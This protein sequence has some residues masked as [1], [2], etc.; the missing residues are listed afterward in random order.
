MFINWPMLEVIDLEFD[1]SDQVLLAQVSFRVESGG[2]LHLRGANGAGKTT[3]LK[4]LAGLYQPTTGQI[5]FNGHAL[6]DNPQAY[7]QQLCFVGHKTGINPYLTVAEN[8]RFDLHYSA[9][10]NTVSQLLSV[11]NLENHQESLCGT[12]SAGQCRQVALLRLWMK[13]TRLWLLDEPFVA[14]DDS[15]QKVLMDKIAS[16][17]KKGGSVVLTSHQ[18][19]QLSA[20]DY[21][22]YVL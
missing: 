6:S 5:V 4:L 13:E 1:Y 21:Q 14:L 12:L 11:F 10:E 17:R 19:I 15:S 8:C 20:N 16:H 2:L 9:N 7:Q 22:D 18:D 3:L